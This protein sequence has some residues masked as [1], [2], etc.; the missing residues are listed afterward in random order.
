MI[1]N[2]SGVH[3][4][5]EVRGCPESVLDSEICVRETIAEA[6]RRS[7]STML[8]LTSHK[9]EPVGVTAVALLAESHISIHTWPELG[10]AAVDIFTC[11][12]TARPREAC[13]FIVEKLQA[14]DHSLMVLPRGCEATEQTA[15]FAHEGKAPQCHRP[16]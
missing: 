10:Y 11:G 2:A 15:W 6:S 5:L 8:N 12:E 14:G 13:E 3:C 4:I 9:F 1:Q 16:A 7:M